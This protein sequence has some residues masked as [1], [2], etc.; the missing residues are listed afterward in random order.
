[1]QPPRYNYQEYNLG[2]KTLIVEPDTNQETNNFTT[3]INAGGDQ[4]FATNNL[5][6]PN[7]ISINNP[8]STSEKNK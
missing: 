1:V 8:A 7:K 4:I 3:K 6:T 2:P 5:K